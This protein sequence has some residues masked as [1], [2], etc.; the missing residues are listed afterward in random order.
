MR[1]LVTLGT[2]DGVHRGHQRLAARLLAD[3]KR[4]KLRPTAVVFDRPPRFYFHPE[5]ATPLLTT[6]EERRELLF[7]LG[8][9]SVR[10][11]PFNRHMAHVPHTRFFEDYLLRRCRAGGLL[12]GPDFA[13]GRGRK[14]D[15]AWLT[16]ACDV[17]GLKFG[18]FPIVRA[19]GMKIGSTRI[20][21]LLL[22]GEV[23][24]AARL[25]G[26]PYSVR[27]PV[28]RGDGLGRRLGVPTANV[29]VPEQKLVPPGVFRVRVTAADS[30]KA[31]GVHLG[32]CNVGVRPTLGGVG[33]RRVEVHLLRFK[34]D[35]YGRRLKLEFLRRI[36][37][38]RRFP[39]LD[40]L[41][42][43]LAKDVK[44]AAR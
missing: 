22:E 2:F 6:A 20:R 9:Q 33:E 25:L 5:L 19:G 7:G 21:E 38:E 29:Q 35:L 1:A 26:R 11:L 8:V 40:A 10:I 32:A 28:V 34:G 43:Q 42:E 37:P 41:K 3:A 4:W 13:F 27:G 12:V 44:A 23:R 17:L 16:R 31:L 36:R 18:V 30:G 14:G 39:S 15:I 24:E